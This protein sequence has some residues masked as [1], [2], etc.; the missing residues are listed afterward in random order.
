MT[1]ATSPSESRSIR[2]L[3]GR[4]IGAPLEPFEYQPAALGPN[5]VELEISHCGMCRSDLHLLDDD[6]KVTTYPFVPGHEIIGFVR[7]MGSAVSHLQRGERVGVGWQSSACLDCDLCLSANDNVCLRQTATCVGRHGG[8]ADRVRVDSRYAFALPKALDSAR[9]APLLCAGIT[10]FAPLNRLKVGGQ[11][12]GVVGVGG[13]GHLALQYG[14]ALGCEVTAF[15][16]SRSKEAEARAL[17]AGRFVATGEDGA[18][19]A[20]ANSVDVLLVTASAD[21]AWPEYL[22][23]V[24]PTGTMCIVGL[25]TGDIRLPPLGV[26]EGQRTIAGSSI[27]SRSAM[28]TMLELSARH[29]VEAHVET[30]PMREANAAFDRL[31]GNQ[32]RYRIV[33]EN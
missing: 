17:G 14:R 1:T 32:A 20:A 12:L 9:T 28:R 3:A 18:L 16:T 15:S 27:G 2:A 23:T 31:R 26:V 6:W 29:G 21:I 33:L 30:F 11:R 4:A 7:E 24:R 19:R 25:P 22:N 10:V 8:Y 5:D 13:L